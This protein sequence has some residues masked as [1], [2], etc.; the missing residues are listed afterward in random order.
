[1]LRTRR[2]FFRLLNPSF[3]ACRAFR[4]RWTLSLPR[5][6]QQLL[7]QDRRLRLQLAAI[8]QLPQRRPVPVER[9]LLLQRS[10]EGTYSKRLQL[11]PKR[12]AAAV[13]VLVL[14]AEVQEGDPRSE[15]KMT[16]R[17]AR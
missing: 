5:A 10:A 16:D 2:F 6:R 4:K 17:G 12:S 8:P 1:M 11:M 13:L 9:Q 14:E 7:R 3:F 15:A